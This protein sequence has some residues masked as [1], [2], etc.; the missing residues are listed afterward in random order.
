MFLIENNQ[1]FFIYI[2]MFNAYV[3]ILIFLKLYKKGYGH[4]KIIHII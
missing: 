3:Y 2:Y 1:M 4:N